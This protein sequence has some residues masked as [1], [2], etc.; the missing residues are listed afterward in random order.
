MTKLRAIA[1]RHFETTLIVIILFGIVAIAFLVQYKLAFLNFFFLPVILAG[2][3]LGKRQAVLAASLCIL[4][5]ALYQIFFRV[6]LRRLPPFSLDDLLNL[7]TW[8]GFLIVTGA[9]IGQIAEQR[10]TKLKNLQIAYT[11]MLE[12]MLKYLEVADKTRPRSVRLSHLAGRIA[13]SAGLATFHVENIKSAALL[14]EAGDLKS[15]IPLYEQAA[16]FMESEGAAAGRPVDD[17]ARVLLKTAASLLKEVEPLLVNYFRHY[18]EEAQVLDKK[19]DSIPLGSSIIAL[20]DVFD[21]LSNGLSLSQWKDEVK[22]LHD[23]RKLAGRAF[24]EAAVEAL[25][26]VAAGPS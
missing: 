24:P 19:L 8:A 15:N 20:A 18:V 22:C 13:E 17:K 6:L 7:I 26:K 25:F 14:L 2:Y 5:I 23:V 21:R 10:E 3:Y 4:L 12:I 16:V 9:A 1:L 11:G